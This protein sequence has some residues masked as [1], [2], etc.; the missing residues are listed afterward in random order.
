MLNVREKDTNRTGKRYYEDWKNMEAQTVATLKGYRQKDIPIGCYNDRTDIL[1]VLDM[2]RNLQSL[3]T[4]S[5]RG[6]LYLL[7]RAL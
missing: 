5:T 2:S 6:N 4:P 3:V 7:A 1:A